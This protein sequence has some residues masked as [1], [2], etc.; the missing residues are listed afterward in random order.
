MLPENHPFGKTNYTCWLVWNGRPPRRCPLKTIRLRKQCL[1]RHN[2]TQKIGSR[3]MVPFV[4]S[5]FEF[6]CCIYFFRRVVFQWRFTTIFSGGS[7]FPFV[8]VPRNEIGY[9]IPLQE[10]GYSFLIV[11]IFKLTVNKCYDMYS[12]VPYSKNGSCHSLLPA[13]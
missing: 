11:I 6:I 7:D 12:C 8:L 5:L 9:L 4:T 2:Q 10:T 1:W 13:F 3:R